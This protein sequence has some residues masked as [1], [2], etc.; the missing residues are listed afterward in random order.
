MDV[1]SGDALK[2]AYNEDCCELIG[3]GSILDSCNI[4]SSGI[5]AKIG[6]A[7]PGI[8]DGA[9]NRGNYIRA[10]SLNWDTGGQV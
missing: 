7:L 10:G 5:G 3:A 8:L 6:E 9:I 2:T 1:G 4:L